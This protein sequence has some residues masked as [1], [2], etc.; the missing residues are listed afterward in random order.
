VPTY[1]VGASLKVFS[2]QTTDFSSEAGE[3][4]IFL[5]T[6]LHQGKKVSGFLGAKPLYYL[7][8]FKIH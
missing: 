5:L 2:L 4:L 3:V 7:I 1:S 8:L 6:F